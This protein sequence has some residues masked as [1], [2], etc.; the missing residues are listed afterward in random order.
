MSAN[1]IVAS[2]VTLTGSIGVIGSWF[3]DKG[4]NNKL[5]L[6]TDFIQ[7]GDH[8]DLLTGI[9]L[10]RRNISQ[11]E[12]DRYRGY[13][14]DMYTEFTSKVAENRKMEIEK[15]EAL[16][17]GRVYSGIGA[18]NAGLIDSLGGLDD[19]VRIAREL[20]GIPEKKKIICNEFPKPKFFDKM[21]DHMIQK[22]ST[23]RIKTSIDLLFPKP[24]ME[25]LHYRI[26]HNGKVM[27][28][29]PLDSGCL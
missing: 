2:P 14:M 5:G 29:L 24:L 7:R 18:L 22:A 27:P 20:A 4:L 8:A 11:A 19:A 15:V 1:H 25:D 17:Q 13:I 9:I 12:E 3:Y 10:P 26:S 6:N 28:I 23:G 16:A 21:L